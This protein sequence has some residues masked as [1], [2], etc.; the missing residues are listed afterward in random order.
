LTSASQTGDLARARELGIAAYLVK[1][2]RRDELRGAIRTATRRGSGEIKI[3]ETDGAASPNGAEKILVVEDSE[4]N[5]LIVQAYLKR[6]RF[7]PEFARDGLEGV[8]KFIADRFSLV[9]MDVQMPVMDG[10]EATRRIREWEREQ[11][12][13]PI[14]IVALTANAFREDEERCRDAGCTA[15]VSK[16]IKKATL[17]EVLDEH[18]GAVPAS[19][20]S[21]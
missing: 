1:P 21:A 6:S 4:D 13:S 19:N 9:L 14:P 7:V 20:G 11:G 3:A 12:L 5:R 10:Y 8:E 15:F 2:V 16:P 17:L 18:L